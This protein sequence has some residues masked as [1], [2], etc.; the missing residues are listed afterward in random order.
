[1][2]LQLDGPGGPDT[3]VNTSPRG[4]TVLMQ[5]Q[6][7]GETLGIPTYGAPSYPG[8][9]GMPAGWFPVG[10]SPETTAVQNAYHPFVEDQTIIPETDLFTGYLEGSFELSD[11]VEAFGEFLFNRRETY[12]NGWRQFWNFGWTGDIYSTGAGNA[13]NYWGDGWQGLNFISPT[14]IT[15]QADSSQKVD[16]YR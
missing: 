13:Y 4:Q 7:P 3:G 15:D 5:Y 1:D 8:D 6:Y 9:F 2:N 11:M 12:Q 14:P 10:Y 16:Y